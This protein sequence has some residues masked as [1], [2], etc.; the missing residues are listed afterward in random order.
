M[1][2]L[3]IFRLVVLLALA[4]AKPVLA[5][6]GMWLPMLLKQ[7]NEADMQ[8]NGLRLSAED[9]YSINRSSLK[10]AI[11]H[12]GG[13]CTGE[14]I[15]PEGLM[16]T[17]HHC[18]YG[19]IQSH[20]SVE[21][22]YLTK[23]FWAMSR[24]EELPNA[25]LTATFIIRMED[26]TARVLEGVTD[27][28]TEAE[29]DTII[30][31]NI[32]AIEK[33]AVKG[34]HYDAKVR[35]FYHGNEFYMFVSETF[36]DVRLVGAPPSSI[37]KFGGDTDNWMW[38]RHTGDFAVFRIYA[39]KENKPA[40]YSTDNV[41]YIPRHFFPISLKGIEEDEFTMVYGFPGRTN[42]YLTSYAVEQIMK[43]SNPAKIKIRT[44]RLNIWDA[45]MKKSDAVRI[46]YAAKYASVSNAHKKWI[47]ENRGLR[48]LDAIEK[49]KAFEKEFTSRIEA[50][51]DLKNKY[52]KLLSE[53]KDIYKQLD[54]LQKP[55]D[56][57]IEAAMAPEALRMANGYMQLHDAA[58]NPNMP[59]EERLKMLE[60]LKN[61]SKGFFKDFNAETDKKIFAALVKMYRDDVDAAFHPE[62]FHMIDKK[63]KG[64]WAAFANELYGKS[65]FVSQE[66]L[67]RF[68]E[69][70]EKAV[71]K[72]GKFS[73]NLVKNLNADPAF[74]LMSSFV[75]LYRSK[76]LPE[77][78]RLN[79]EVNR[80]NRTWMAA[81]RE[82]MHEKKYYPDANSTLR[83]TYGKAKGYEPYDG[84]IYK[85]YT[86][87][88]GIMEKE[89]P[90]IDDY[91]V[92]ERLKELH[93]KKDYGQY[94][95]KDGNLRIA[96][97]ASNH[98]TGGNSGSPV[99]NGDG[100]LIGTNFDRNWE[101]T[102]SDIMYDPD[103][104]RNITVDVRYTLFVIDKFAG[105]G[106]LLNEMKIIKPEPAPKVLLPQELNVKPQP[107]VKEAK[108]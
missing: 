69:A 26:V 43:V 64:D 11:V 16:L 6:E 84:A 63:Y 51:T 65:I 35:A 19:Q 44:T 75:S 101:G 21:K 60:K 4:F 12:F 87:L 9:L 15:S 37:G 33:E 105:A 62:A 52:G 41:P 49:K 106:Y 86:T 39:N 29:R 71:K 5:D 95:D 53:Y 89:D 82:I 59:K 38:P 78:T 8:K 76:I 14:V 27:N 77:Y 48:K 102:M 58:G 1:M 13:G 24:S 34:T 40:D 56:Y 96:F 47:G 3:R 55:F 97:C 23:G 28:L 100:H 108:K 103:R 54:G 98:T 25:G 99:L 90:A 68:I 74:Q 66:R 61:G 67:N 107:K 46:Q 45:D 57:F 10:D 17:N 7:M 31:R 36:R 42:Q 85:Y 20:S 2:N 81:Q 72:D 88:D 30:G 92:P 73:K 104:V 32:K 79:N 70:E 50:N 93:K 18:G 94:A 22:D 83:V 91:E 80:L